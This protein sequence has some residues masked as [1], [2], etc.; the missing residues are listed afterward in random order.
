MDFPGRDFCVNIRR[1]HPWKTFSVIFEKPKDPISVQR[2]Q[3]LHRLPGEDPG[4]VA[5]GGEEA[6]D[7]Q[8]PDLQ[9]GARRAVLRE[10]LRPRQG[11]RVHCAATT[12][13]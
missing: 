7:H 10:D 4:L 8:L 12:N 1:Y 5:R 2:D 13:G 3:D 11:L 6:G 9:A